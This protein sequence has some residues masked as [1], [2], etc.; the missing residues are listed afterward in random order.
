MGSYKCVC[1]FCGGYIQSGNEPVGF[2]EEF[3]EFHE[4]WNQQCEEFLSQPCPHYGDGCEDS[5]KFEL[6]VPEEG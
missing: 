3:H 2:G 5:R 6:F 4:L 1:P